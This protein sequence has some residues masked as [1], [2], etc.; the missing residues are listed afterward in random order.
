MGLYNTVNDFSI[1]CPNCGKLLEDFQSK[2]GES[3]M[4]LVSTK[5]IDNFYTMCDTCRTWV[6]FDRKK[7]APK[8]KKRELLPNDPIEYFQMKT[9]YVPRYD[10]KK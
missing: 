4:N 2:C 9:E 3:C 6:E 1:P 7:D 10:E 5:E 8:K